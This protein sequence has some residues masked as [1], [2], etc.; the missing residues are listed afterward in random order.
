MDVYRWVGQLSMVSS[1]GFFFSFPN[2]N[3]NPNRLFMTTLS[4]KLSFFNFFCAREFMQDGKTPANLAKAEKKKEAVAILDNWIQVRA[5]HYW[6]TCMF[7]YMISYAEI[8]ISYCL[9][10]LFNTIFIDQSNTF[11]YAVMIFYYL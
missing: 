5:N 8:C 6:N 4:F 1:I 11:M 2:P 3:P 10:F 9:R 7:E